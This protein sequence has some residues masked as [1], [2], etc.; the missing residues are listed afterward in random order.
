MHVRVAQHAEHGEVRILVVDV[1][2]FTM[3][4]NDAQVFVYVTDPETGDEVATT[5]RKGELVNI[6]QP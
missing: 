3:A 4:P 1:D 2:G 5:V 6:R